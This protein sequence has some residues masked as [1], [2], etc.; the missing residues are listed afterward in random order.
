MDWDRQVNRRTDREKVRG[1][2]GDTDR[3]TQQWAPE[4]RSSAVFLSNR[5]LRAVSQACT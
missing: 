3:E 2:I 5:M 4:D 1:Q